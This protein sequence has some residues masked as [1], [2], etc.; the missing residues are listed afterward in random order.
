MI[1]E[2]LY[3]MK[4]IVCLNCPCGV[5]SVWMDRPSKLSRKNETEDVFGSAVQ[6]K[7]EEIPLYDRACVSALSSQDAVDRSDGYAKASGSIK[8]LS[9]FLIMIWKSCVS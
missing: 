6:E 5:Q 1:E 2:V 7:G 4:F 9:Y 3:S 8:F